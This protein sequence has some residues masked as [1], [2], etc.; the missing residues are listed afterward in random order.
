MFDKRCPA[1]MRKISKEYEFCPYCGHNIKREQN[2]KDFGLLGREDNLD[3]DSERFG[4]RMPFGFNSLFS[5]LI[6][7]LDKQFRE[8]DKEI[9]KDIEKEKKLEKKP[10]F[11]SKGLSI[12]ISSRTGEKPEIKIRG[13]G[14][15]LEALREEIEPKETRRKIRLPREISEY[16]AKLLSKLPKKE[17]ETKVRRLS[18]KVI[19]ELSLPGV[20]K[21]EDIIINQLENSIEIK[22]FSKDKVYFKLLPINLPILNYKL[23][24][25]N[26]I[27]ELKAK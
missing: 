25:E 3:T 6:K 1:C 20:K 24:K 16:K 10:G 21:L 15:G 7:Q 2:E 8:L 18:N 26:L 5:S 12:S 22:A 14:P 27:L 4:M 11:I 17:A 13:F 23:D 19:Y 9:G